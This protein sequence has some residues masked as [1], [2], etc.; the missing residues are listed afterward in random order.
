MFIKLTQLGCLMMINL[1]EIKLE[2]LYVFILTLTLLNSCDYRTP[3]MD[4][5]EK[6]TKIKFSDSINVIEDRFE[7]AGPDYSMFY[8]FSLNESDCQYFKSKIQKTEDWIKKDKEWTFYKT[9]DGIIYN[10]TFSEQDCK[11][12]YNE[13]LI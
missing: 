2:S 11:V 3:S 1:R 13:D 9:V 8:K 4:R 7:S 10:I 6:I 12:S 5:F